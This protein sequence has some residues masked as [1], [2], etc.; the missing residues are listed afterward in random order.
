MHLTTEHHRQA[1][2]ATRRPA[3]HQGV[4]RGVEVQVPGLPV[5]PLQFRTRAG[6]DQ[7]RVDQAGRLI[8]SAGI[9]RL[10]Y[11]PQ[12][13][14]HEAKGRGFFPGHLAAAAGL[15]QHGADLRC[16]H[17]ALRRQVATASGGP[18]REQVHQPDSRPNHPICVTVKF[19]LTSYVLTG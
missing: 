19:H 11:V 7:H 15:A 4:V 8:D 2:R 9:D 5:V 14:G 3:V 17:V 18:R 16:P 12:L 1:G 10:E 13:S 6:A